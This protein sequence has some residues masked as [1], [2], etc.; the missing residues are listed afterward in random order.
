MNGDSAL[1]CANIMSSA[2]KTSSMITGNS[3]H[4]FFLIMNFQSWDTNP[5]AIKQSPFS[6]LIF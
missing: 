4:F 5:P 1:L 3:H 6:L 2:A